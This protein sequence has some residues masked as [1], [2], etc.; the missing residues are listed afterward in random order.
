[1]AA[2]R[3]RGDRLKMVGRGVAI[4]I[5]YREPPAQS[6]NAFRTDLAVVIDALERIAKGAPDA[7]IF[8]RLVLTTV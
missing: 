7:A 1:M 8:A 6:I 5:A 2:K 3:N 4:N